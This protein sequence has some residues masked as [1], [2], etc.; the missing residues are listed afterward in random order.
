MIIK[1]IKEWSGGEMEWADG[2]LYPVLQRLEKEELIRSEW[3]LSDGSRPRKYYEITAKG[4]KELI[5]EKEQW[6]TVNSVL[7]KILQIEIKPN[8]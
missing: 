4:K 8:V 7:S 6:I 3:I 2:M 5:V 1:K